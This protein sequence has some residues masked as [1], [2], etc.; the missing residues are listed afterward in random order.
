M[1]QAVGARP[2]ALDLLHLPLDPREIRHLLIAPALLLEAGADARLQQHRLER[3]GQVVLGAELD[4][5]HHAVEVVERRD[6]DHRDV[7]QPGIVLEAPQHLEAVDLA[8]S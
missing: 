2:L 3:L 6:H 5:A 8:A 4:A 1:Q 7:A